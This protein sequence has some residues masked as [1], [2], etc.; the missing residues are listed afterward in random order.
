MY[1]CI[2]NDV[3]DRA[4]QQA[5]ANGCRSLDELTRHTGCGTTCGCCLPLA[6][7]LLAESQ[8]LPPSRYAAIHTTPGLAAVAA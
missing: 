7:D 4:I 5:I 6:A 1:V 8:P 3:T 2:C